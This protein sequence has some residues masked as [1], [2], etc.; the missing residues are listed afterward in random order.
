MLCA[1]LRQIRSAK[2]HPHS[3]V[4]TTQRGEPIRP[5][6]FSKLRYDALQKLDPPIRPLRLYHTQAHVLLAH[7]VGGRPQQARQAEDADG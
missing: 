2:L 4:F 5:G 7:R 1:T 3:F 6:A